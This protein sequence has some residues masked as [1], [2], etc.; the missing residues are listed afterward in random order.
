MLDIMT[1][2]QQHAWLVSA[3]LV[4]LIAVFIVEMY[5]QAIAPRRITPQM[6]VDLMNNE[7]AMI[8]DL[9]QQLLFQAGHIVGAVNFPAETLV[10]DLSKLDRYK[11]R[12]I[13]LVDQTGAEAIR[14]SAKLGKA[15]QF[16]AVKILAGGMNAWHTSGFPSEK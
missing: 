14:I 1:F 10:K 2:A 8:I 16:T 7:K 13:I 9:R 6:T 4:T 12:M 5:A 11:D 3:L 15:K